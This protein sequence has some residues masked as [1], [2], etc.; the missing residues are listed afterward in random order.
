MWEAY[1]DGPFFFFLQTFAQLNVLLE[2]L[3]CLHLPLYLTP[4]SAL[5]E[6]RPGP[7][8]ERLSVEHLSLLQPVC[9]SQL[10]VPCEDLL[11]WNLPSFTCEVAAAAVV[12]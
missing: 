3:F 2:T 6:P 7:Q 10:F 5:S 9:V 4:L 11:P 1:R 8:L 12:V